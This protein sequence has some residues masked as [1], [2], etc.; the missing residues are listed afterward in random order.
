GRRL[1]GEFCQD[2]K[3]ILQQTEAFG[4]AVRAG[5]MYAALADMAG[6]T[7]EAA[8][9]R[10]SETIWG[11]VAGRKLYLTGGVGARGSGE[12]FGDP[13]ELPNRSAY[14]ET[15]AAIASALWNQRMFQ[16]TGEARYVDVFERTIYNGFL[17]G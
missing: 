10:T 15:C 5:Y 12:A 7:G 1:M 3:P 14:T 2:A 8:Y 6:L 11:D 4:H 16:L 17:V 9:R 13:Y